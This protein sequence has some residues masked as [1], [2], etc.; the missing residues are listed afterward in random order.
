MPGTSAE[1]CPPTMAAMPHMYWGGWVGGC[2]G[3][4]QE[5]VPG[6]AETGSESKPAKYSPVPGT[7]TDPKRR[8]S[9]SGSNQ[10]S[11]PAPD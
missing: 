11:A 3:S 1:H 8:E 9:T 2:S 10:L 4:N 5:T 6:T 7:D